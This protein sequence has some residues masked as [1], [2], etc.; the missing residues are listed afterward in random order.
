MVLNSNSSPTGLEKVLL[1]VTGATVNLVFYFREIES[2]CNNFSFKKSLK[3]LELSFS[4]IILL[5]VG[6][7]VQTA[8]NGKSA[9]FLTL[10]NV[11]IEW[12]LNQNVVCL[13]QCRS[14]CWLSTKF[15]ITSIR[16]EAITFFIW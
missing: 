12:N 9:N 5:S 7:F 2:A 16:F 15:D 11:G 1:L 8:T 14:L 10:N 3:I 4:D 6:N 13:N